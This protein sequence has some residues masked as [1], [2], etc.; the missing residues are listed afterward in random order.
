MQAFYHWGQVHTE[1]MCSF[2]DP[3]PGGKGHLDPNNVDFLCSQEAGSHP[4]TES[5]QPSEAGVS[6]GL[7]LGCSTPQ[8][9][10]R[11]LPALRLLAPSQ[12]TG[13]ALL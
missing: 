7:G 4:R 11:P 9:T 12:P 3:R 13:L 5:R 8:V 10:Y 1:A 2:S 6:Q